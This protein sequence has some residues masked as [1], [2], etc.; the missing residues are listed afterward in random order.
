M[1]KVIL[2]IATTLDGFI[3]K[4]DGNLDW[5]TSTPP[6]ET[7]DYGYAALLNSTEAIVMG[8]K[9]YE[10]VLGF[11]I[12]WPYPDYKT[13]VVS[14]DKNFTVKTDNTFAAGG[15]LRGLVARLKADCR[16]DIWLVGGGKL[17]SAFLN[18]ELLDKMIIT[19]V[20]KNLGEGIRLF[21]DT[22]KEIDWTLTDVQKFNTGLVN[23]TYVRG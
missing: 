21:P 8:R 12:D 5:L 14:S 13:Y 17:I 1:P 11:G 19:I 4:P 6:P 3:A 7:G 10:E 20:P 15:D 16:K 9:T 2:Y 23:L 22:T 18:E